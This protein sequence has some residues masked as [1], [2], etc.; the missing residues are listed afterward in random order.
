MPF[1]AIGLVSFTVVLL[2]LINI[3]S[4]TA[5]TAMFALT[6]STLYISYLI[7]IILLVM[8]RIRKEPI[9]F[10]PWTLGRWGMPVNLFSIVF[11]T[12]VIIFVPFPPVLPVTAE[13]MNYCGPVF[14]GLIILLIFDW[15]VRGRITFT[16]PLKELLE[17]RRRSSSTAHLS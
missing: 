9:A 1:R 10:G 4:T 8:K 17:P 3:A 6:T 12:F 5:L 2:S 13:N 14:V 11:G 15:M 16:G 7:P